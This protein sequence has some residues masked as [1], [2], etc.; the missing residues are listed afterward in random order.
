MLSFSSV[1]EAYRPDP[2]SSAGVN[3]F[4]TDIELMFLDTMFFSQNDSH[5][6]HN[7]VSGILIMS[8]A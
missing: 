3:F 2:P 5:P 6:D 8:L 7:M 4:L 1:A